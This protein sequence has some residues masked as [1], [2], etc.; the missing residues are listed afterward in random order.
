MALVSPHT[1]G[2]SILSAVSAASGGVDIVS[3]GGVEDVNSGRVP[4][5]TGA[6]GF[7]ALPWWIGRVWCPVQQV[8]DDA[9]PG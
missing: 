2:E 9:L 5:G 3:A 4:V 1:R 7:P 6:V 8:C